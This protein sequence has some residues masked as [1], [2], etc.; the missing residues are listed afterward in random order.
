MPPHSSARHWP[1]LGRYTGQLGTPSTHLEDRCSPTGQ[2]A[3]LGS[4]SE[5]EDEVGRLPHSGGQPTATTAAF[6]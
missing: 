6:R 4:D 1:A 2:H 5:T 3:T